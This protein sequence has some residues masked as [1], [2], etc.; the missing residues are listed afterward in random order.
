MRCPV[1]RRR[2]VAK[3]DTVCRTCRA[4]IRDYIDSG[5]I[6]HRTVPLVADVALV[7]H[8]LGIDQDRA[9][10]VLGGVP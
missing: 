5:T 10:M 1:C 8:K 3:G 9:V 2:R 4:F 6:E 7:M